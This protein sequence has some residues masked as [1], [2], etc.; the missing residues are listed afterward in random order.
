MGIV[1][2][3]YRRGA[4][5]FV[6]FLTVAMLAVATVAPLYSGDAVAESQQRLLT[7]IK[8]LSSDEL[9]GRGVGLK[10]LDVAADYIRDQ[11]AKAGLGLE[12][13]GGGP[14]QTFSMSTGAVLGTPNSLELA[15]PENKKVTLTLNTDF[16]PQSYGGAGAFL[17]DVVFCGYGIEAADKG[18]DDVAGINLKGKVAV[19]MRRVPQQGNPHG[20]F[21]DPK[22]GM[23]Q[24]AELRTKLDHAFTKGAVAVLFVN[25]PYSGRNE[26]E[27][28]K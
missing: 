22:G 18:Y 6:A 26:L 11:F 4:G 23:S 28:A 20:Q 1:L 3:A 16:I 8:F 2:M 17:G 12:A 14:F 27:Q 19:V 13:V 5:R 25:D 10:G 24:H 7:D 9:E 15:G 21:S